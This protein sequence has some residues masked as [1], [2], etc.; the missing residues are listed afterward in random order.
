MRS[1]VVLALCAMLLC[2]ATPAHATPTLDRQAVDDLVT[3]QLAA[4]GA[5]GVAIAITHGNQVF[6]RGYGNAGDDRPIT[7]DTQF[8]IA[9]LSKS[10]TATAVL[11]LVT[12]GQVDLDEPVTTYLPEFSPD[13]PRGAE[14]TVRQLLNQ[15]SGLTDQSF[16]AAT[17]PQPE[18]R[19]SV[20]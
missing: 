12:R 18:D 6:T 10:F 15:T 20:V 2:V 4:T 11:Q 19:K 5:P 16:P 9:S 13:D 8:R 17:L 7:A 14:I 1:A 3:E